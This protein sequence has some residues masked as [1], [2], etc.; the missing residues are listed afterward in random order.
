M[1]YSYLLKH[2]EL[3]QYAIG[4]TYDQFQGLLPQFS[5]ALRRA[6][7]EKTWKKKR[8][9]EP[10][11][12]RKATLKTD[13]EK[14]FCIL[15]YYKIYPTFR[16]AQIA[17]GFDKRNIQLWIRFLQQVL[18]TA[19][20]YELE[21]PKRKIRSHDEWL[22]ICPELSD[23]IV[24]STERPIQRPK[25]KERQKLYYSGKKKHHTV[26]NQIIVDPKTKRILAVSETVEGKR[27]DKRLFVEDPLYTAIPPNAHGRADKAY[28]G[29][30]EHPFLTWTIPKK[31][32]RGGELTIE[33]K[34]INKQI[35]KIRIYVEH[36]NAYMK[37]FNILSNRF[38]NRIER[39]ELPFKTIAA[40]YNFTRPPS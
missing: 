40:I 36:P 34:E 19:L 16:F 38:R 24:D 26:K 6:E 25:D 15:W 11:G 12:G 7:H 18:F 32:P 9:R 10:G 3:F 23:F 27:S 31:K 37:H 22:E 2:H 14:L 21:L 39:A 5:V 20:G 35:S 1:N 8:L 28:I 13:V 4:I 30:D 33:E 29:I 17:L